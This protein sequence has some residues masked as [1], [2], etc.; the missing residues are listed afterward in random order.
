MTACRASSSGS[1][2]QQVVQLAQRSGSRLAVDGTA[3]TRGR[4]VG[5]HEVDR[6]AHGPDL[7]RLLVGHLDPVGVLELLHQRV[8]VERVRPQVVA[9][10]RRPP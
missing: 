9:E 1:S 5:E 8:E 10:V 2:F 6:G 3:R 4:K 7:R